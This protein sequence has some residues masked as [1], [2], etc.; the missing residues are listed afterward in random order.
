MHWMCP[1]T[2]QWSHLW[3]AEGPR[4]WLCW[5]SWDIFLEVHEMVC[6]KCEET[7]CVWTT[8][9]LCLSIQA[10]YQVARGQSLTCPSTPSKSASEE[11]LQPSK[12]STT[13]LCYIWKVLLEYFSNIVGAFISL[14]IMPFVCKM[15]WVV[16]K[17]ANV[18]GQSH[19]EV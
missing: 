18:W 14:G 4:A 12:H 2:S 1:I 15:T 10:F 7:S 8:F 6:S 13:V 5:S 9:L 3:H 19:H 11:K 17:R 16:W